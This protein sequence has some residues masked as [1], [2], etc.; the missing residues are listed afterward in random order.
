MALAL[1]PAKARL[2][3]TVA[4]AQVGFWCAT[5]DAP[6]NRLYVGGTDFNIHVYDLPAVQPAKGGPL[7]GHGS[8]VTALVCLPGTQTLV[9]GSFDKQLLWWQPAGRLA[10]VR[11]V[12]SSGRVNQL[13]TS[14]D[15]LL[16][17]ATM[18]DLA[19]VWDAKTGKPLA[20]LK[21]GHPAT[22][23]IGR[24]NPRYGVAFSP[25]GERVVTGDRGGTI[26]LWEAAT[27]KLLH[28]SEASAFY[29]QAFYRDTQSSEY[30]WGGVRALEFAPDGKVLVAGGMGPADQNSA[31][32]DG[33][34]RLEAFD[35]ATGKSIA[36]FMNAPKG[37]LNTIVFH[38]GSDWV[39]AAGGGGQAGSAGIGS[40]WLWNHRRRGKGRKP[41]SPVMHKS[42]IV[43]R[44]VVLCPDGANVLAV[45]MLRDLTAGRIEV[46]DLTGQ[47][48]PPKSA[49]VK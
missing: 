35:S 30:E 15:G 48:A 20:D 3:R 19:R 46:W 25:D 26:C 17:A 27:G 8:Y 49:T 12:A 38:P 9:S 14:P 11:R 40:L 32:I 36:A 29:S 4:K 7:K 41:A 18:Q 34:M 47:A 42:D 37:M 44:Q 45:G 6:G 16:I 31:G 21:G 13:A 28:R 39:I 10:P 5:R 24:R 1:E 2:L 43:I 23:R 33:P 22:T